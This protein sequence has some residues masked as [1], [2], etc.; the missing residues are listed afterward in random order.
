M[1]DDMKSSAILTPYGFE[2]G[3]AN[4]LRCFEHEGRVCM[5]VDT[6]RASLEI[7]VTKTGLIRVWKDGK[8]LKA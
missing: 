2:W 1:T 6:P 3:A 7:Y 4:V 5:K 8:E